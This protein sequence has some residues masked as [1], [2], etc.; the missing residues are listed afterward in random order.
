MEKAEDFIEYPPLPQDTDDYEMLSRKCSDCSIDTIFPLLATHKKSAASTITQNSSSRT[1][2]PEDDISTSELSVRTDIDTSVKPYSLNFKE[3]ALTR[4]GENKENVDTDKGRNC[5]YGDE[6]GRSGEKYEDTSNGKHDKQNHNDHEETI[7]SFYKDTII[8]YCFISDKTDTGQ[9]MDGRS[10]ISETNINYINRSTTYRESKYFRRHGCNSAGAYQDDFTCRSGSKRNK[11]KDKFARAIEKICALAEAS[12]TFKR[13]SKQA[14]VNLNKDDNIKTNYS[15]SL[16][17][18]IYNIQL[19][20]THSVQRKQEKNRQEKNSSH[21]KRKCSSLLG[22]NRKNNSLI[23]VVA[24]KLAMQ[25][26]TVRNVDDENSSWKFVMKHSFPIIRGRV[27][28]TYKPTQREKA[29]RYVRLLKEMSEEYKNY[30][31]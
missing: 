14:K 30:R 15:V 1:L 29:N 4:V 24:C 13:K 8:S 16:T 9:N 31:R 18:E 11:A 5:N 25:K 2:K 22:L 12:T 28:P 10:T 21:V 7:H 6:K 23:N 3:T 17:K 20:L 26:H 19:K 27:F